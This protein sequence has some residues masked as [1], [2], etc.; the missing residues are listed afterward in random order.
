MIGSRTRGGIGHG[1]VFEGFLAR[2]F[3]AKTQKGPK[4]PRTRRSGRRSQRDIHGAHA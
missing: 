2:G 3:S 4:D 1:S